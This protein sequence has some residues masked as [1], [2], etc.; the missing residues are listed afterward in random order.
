[1]CDR[2]DGH[3][4]SFLEDI[5]LSNLADYQSR[6]MFLAICLEDGFQREQEGFNVDVQNEQGN[7]GNL[8]AKFDVR[9]LEV[10]STLR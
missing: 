6:R 10:F 7:L 3:A 9:G 2:A 4:S 1:M 5:V 8:R